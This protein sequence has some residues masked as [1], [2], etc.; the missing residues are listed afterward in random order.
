MKK[1]LIFLTCCLVGGCAY[2]NPGTTLKFDPLNYEVYFYDTKDNDVELAELSYNVDTGAFAMKDL[3]IRNNASDV[4]EAN[5]A[6]MMAFVEQQ[7]AANEGIIAA[8][9]GLAELTN[10]LG[11][12]TSKVIRSMPDVDAGV[13]I[14]GVGSIGV[15]T[16]GQGDA[17]DTGGDGEMLRPVGVDLPL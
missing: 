15:E 5:V 11:L 13:E 1:I 9:N 7:R 17:V 16:E 3:K 4:R 10:M 8:F 14:D 2:A 12:A 6:Q